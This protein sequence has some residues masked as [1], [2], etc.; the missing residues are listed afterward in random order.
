[1]GIS[2][3]DHVLTDDQVV[4]AFGPDMT[5]ALEVDPGAEVSLQMK[6]GASHRPSRPSR[7]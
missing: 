1:M 2:T 7:A 3:A 5:P 4:C 6:D